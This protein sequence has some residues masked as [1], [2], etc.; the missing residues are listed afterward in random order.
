MLVSMA[1]CDDFTILRFI[2]LRVKKNFETGNEYPCNSIRGTVT[3][4][5]SPLVHGLSNHGASNHFASLQTAG[6]LVFLFGERPL[7]IVDVKV[8]NSGL[9]S[10]V[11][12]NTYVL[13]C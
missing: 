12:R 9:Y 7:V 1:D 6:V 11:S 13:Y 5:P 4:S 2:Q 10:V 3:K 8:P